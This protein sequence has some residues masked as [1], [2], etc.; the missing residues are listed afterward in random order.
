MASTTSSSHDNEPT[1][2]RDLRARRSLTQ[3]QVARNLNLSQADVSRLEH[4]RDVLVSTLRRFVEA[5]GGELELVARYPGD[6][7][8]RISLDAEE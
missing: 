3:R 2:L 8:S 5:T 7:T 6:Q 1:T 4:R